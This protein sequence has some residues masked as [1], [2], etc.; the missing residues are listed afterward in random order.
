M[1]HYFL[2]S[3][4]ALN[5]DVTAHFSG[6]FIS[7]ACR[8]VD[9]FHHNILCIGG[10]PTWGM[11]RFAI[12]LSVDSLATVVFWSCLRKAYCLRLQ[13]HF[14]AVLVAFL[15]ELIGLA[16][17]RASRPEE[18]LFVLQCGSCYEK[19]RSALGSRM[20]DNDLSVAAA[21]TTSALVE[22][23]AHCNKSRNFLISP[24][25]LFPLSSLATLRVDGDQLVD[26][27]HRLHL[28]S[29]R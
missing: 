16:N 21:K 9:Y 12:L 26:L 27:P 3:V 20:V 18:S 25:L 14:V 28:C 2:H 8:K 7:C 6:P 22:F 23:A 19:Y 1:E 10:T 5:I 15:S 13:L 11:G 29:S 24:P 17:R 4:G